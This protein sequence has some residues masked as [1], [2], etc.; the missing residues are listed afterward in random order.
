MADT[1]NKN[2]LIL[3]KVRSISFTDPETKEIF[4]RLTSLE[5]SSLN[6]TAE[7]DEITDAIGSVITTLYRA[8]KAK[9]SATNSL[10]SF[11]LMAAQYGSNK[12][13]ATSSNK[14]RGYTYEVLEIADG[15]VTLEN[16]PIK[17]S[18]EFIYSIVSKDIGKSYKAGATV[19]ESE[20][21]VSDSSKEI[22]TPTGLTG[23]VYIEYAYETEKAIRVKNRGSQFPKDCG[24]TIYA[25]F[26]DKCN[27]NLKYSGAILCSKAKL[28]PESI[29]IALTST[30]KHPFEFD[31]FKD[32]CD[33]T[34]DDLF[35]TVVSE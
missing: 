9:F 6:C 15:K 10:L 23:K 8:K 30:G 14:L 18:I 13:V 21:V 34:N 25:Y 4:C 19:S 5:D 16:Q 24:A 17:D 28:N 31:I 20:F 32:Y 7:G 22:Q 2:E 26:R 1:F 33:E 11:D 35:E 27:P 12:E 3:D 29:E